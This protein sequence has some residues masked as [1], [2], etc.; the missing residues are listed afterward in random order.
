MKER[1]ETLC[2]KNIAT[3]AELTV[4]LSNYITVIFVMA[5]VAVYLIK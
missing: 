5:I 3:A 4:G 2:E 1:I